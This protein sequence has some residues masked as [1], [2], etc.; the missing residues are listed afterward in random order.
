MVQVAPIYAALPAL[1]LLYVMG[2]GGHVSVFWLLAIVWATDIGAY[3][4]GRLIGACGIDIDQPG[5]GAQL[6]DGLGVTYAQQ[7]GAAG[8]HRDPTVHVEGVTN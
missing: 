7:A 6:G 8:Y 1:A 5:N 2:M 4:C 3:A